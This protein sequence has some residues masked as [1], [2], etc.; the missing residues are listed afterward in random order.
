MG[1]RL[2]GKPFCFYTGEMST[3]LLYLSGLGIL[4]GSLSY[5]AFSAFQFMNAPII[6]GSSDKKPRTRFMGQMMLAFGGFLLGGQLLQMHQD[7][8]ETARQEQRA[9][10][11]LQ[12]MAAARKESNR[13]GKA[14]AVRPE[15]RP[16][17]GQLIEQEAGA[18]AR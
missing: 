15:H 5:L 3:P 13:Q 1:L 6:T 8:V 9:T 14:W 2:E 16:Q 10:Q 18:K 7:N 17:R 12:Q 11:Q 4:G